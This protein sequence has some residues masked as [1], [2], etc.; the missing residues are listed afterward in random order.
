M[1]EKVW[2]I[3]AMVNGNM[4]EEM[5]WVEEKG[6]Q[7]FLD[8]GWVQGG[9]P[10]AWKAYEEIHFSDQYI[11]RWVR[12]GDEYVNRI[13]KEMMEDFKAVV[14]H[15]TKPVL[16]INKKTLREGNGGDTFWDTEVSWWPEDGFVPLYERGEK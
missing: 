16:Y 15:P 14:K 7:D 10:V 11:M 12:E 2:G 3:F 5:V 13:S 1:D 4:V 6:W 9:D 8:K